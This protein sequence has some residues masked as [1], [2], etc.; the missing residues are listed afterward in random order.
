[1]AY[2]IGYE[3]RVV[4]IDLRPLDYEDLGDSYVN[5][6]LIE[7]VANLFDKYDLVKIRVADEDGVDDIIIG[8]FVISSDGVS[9]ADSYIKNTEGTIIAVGATSDSGGGD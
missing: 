5:T 8:G 4:T 6:D 7:T 3:G 9:T 1:M 2:M